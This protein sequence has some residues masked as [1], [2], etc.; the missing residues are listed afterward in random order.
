M[1][2]KTIQNPGTYWVNI[3]TTPSLCDVAIVCE[4][5]AFPFSL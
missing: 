5:M 1:N 3:V 2:R 4:V